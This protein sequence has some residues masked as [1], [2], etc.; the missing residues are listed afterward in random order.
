MRSVCACLIGC[1]MLAA[2]MAHAQSASLALPKTI[3]AGSAF[4]VST[5][6]SGKA[7]LYIVGLGQVLK[8][9]V[10][11]GQT[12]GFPLGALYSAGPYATVL[13]QDPSPSDNG[14]SDR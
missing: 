9:E 12:R 10:E 11:M 2:L 4:S 8:R 3:E 14:S 5:S 6:G 13:V 1:G 7:T